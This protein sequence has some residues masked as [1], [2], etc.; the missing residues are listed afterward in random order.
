MGCL[1]YG[2]VTLFC[3]IYFCGEF[4]IE[5]EIGL[6][7]VVFLFVAGPIIGLFVWCSASDAEQKRIEE[8]KRRE[9]AEQKRIEEEKQKEEHNLSLINQIHSEYS[10]EECRLEQWS[11][12]PMQCGVKP[13]G[14]EISSKTREVFTCLDQYYEEIK[15][16]DAQLY[17]L[18][19]KAKDILS[20]P[21]CSSSEEK[22]SYLQS[23]LP[24]LNEIK[25]HAQKLY[26]E[27][28]SK[29]IYITNFDP[30]PLT[31]LRNAMRALESSKRCISTF[32]N[33]PKEFFAS[34]EPKEHTYFN[35]SVEPVSLNFGDVKAYCYSQ[36]I[37]L[38]EGDYFIAAVDSEELKIVVKQ[39]EVRARFDSDRNEYCYDNVLDADSF[40]V[41]QGHECTTW[42]HTRKDGS[43][44]MR[45]TYNP[46]KHFRY[47][48][49]RYGIVSFAL[50]EYEAEFEFSSNQAYESLIAA[51]NAYCT[52]NTIP[53]DPVP[54]LLNLF[55]SLGC[56]S[57]AIKE[58]RE[59]Q[60]IH[61]E[62]ELPMFRIITSHS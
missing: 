46:V 53:T 38:F 62:A 39:E 43:P 57:D 2:I 40:V 21:E 5:S 59:K 7:F 11:R 45:Y 4:G 41:K 49:V 1:I 31:Q 9:E 23:K 30:A 33:S 24:E 44:D 58:M 15:Q 20:C 56:D 18:Q 16:Y 13:E 17:E 19:M 29:K 42:Q 35:S 47:D 12:N 36:I 32:G 48:V 54:E 27:G 28:Q 34:D 55:D 52:N 14:L 3:A 37:L 10:M 61:N 22:L 6:Y 60:K 50:G 26:S 51:Q 8:E 25:D